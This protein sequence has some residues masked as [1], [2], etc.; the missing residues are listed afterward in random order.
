MRVCNSVTCE[1]LDLG[2]MFGGRFDLARAFS[3]GQPVPA[4]TCIHNPSNGRI[5]QYCC[6]TKPCSSACGTPWRCVGSVHRAAYVITFDKSCTLIAS[7]DQ[8]GVLHYARAAQGQLYG[9]YL[10]KQP[11]YQSQRS[12][13]PLKRKEVSSAGGARIKAQ[14]W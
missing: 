11:R 4:R 8:Q 9:S 3:H 13:N 6:H 10:T 2:Q 1:R 7:W 5:A 14:H 12:L